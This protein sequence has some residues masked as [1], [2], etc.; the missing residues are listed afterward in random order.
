MSKLVIWDIDGT[1][2]H[3]FGTGTDALQITYQEMYNVKDA[4]KNI[5][6]SGVIDN[7]VMAEINEKNNILNFNK[8]AFTERYR[9]HLTVAMMSSKTPKLIEGV[10]E[11]LDDL[12]RPGFYHVIGT[13]NCFSG[14]EVKLQLTGLDHYFEHGA[15]GDDVDNRSQLLRL[16]KERAERHY[17]IKFND[18][19]V[20]VIGD[21]P[22]D[23][24]SAK[25]NNFISVATTTGGYK[26]EQLAS[27]NPD[28]I[29]T[30]YS[31]LNGVIENHWPRAFE[32]F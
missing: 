28:Y 11:V 20:M 27:Y 14:A 19:D 15:Y 9:H 7:Q 32:L 5:D 29:I 26:E 22:H 2:M 3:C 6:L 23:V 17:R 1:L 13:G 18:F 24:V 30:N 10:L 16:A 31:E 4:M 8:E 12:Q 21:T 25:D